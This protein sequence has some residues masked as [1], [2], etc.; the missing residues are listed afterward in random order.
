VI[1]DWKDGGKH[2]TTARDIRFMSDLKYEFRAAAPP[3]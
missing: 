3:R 2:E 1:F